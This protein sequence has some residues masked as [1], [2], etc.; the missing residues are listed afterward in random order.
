MD[1][2]ELKHAARV[3]QALAHPLRLGVMQTLADGERN[4]TELY[5]ALACSQSMMSQQLRILEEQ[6]LIQTR[7]EGTVKVCAIRN[8]DFL[9]LFHCMEKHLQKIRD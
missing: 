6:G 2:Q 3:M 9:Q 1:G 7:K 8:P 4:V 5:E